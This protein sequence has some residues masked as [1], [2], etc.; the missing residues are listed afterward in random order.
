MAR[1]SFR[2]IIGI[3]LV[4]AIAV[5]AALMFAPLG[6][7]K[8]GSNPIANAATTAK[9]NALNAA[10]DAS[11]VKSAVQDALVSHSGDIAQATGLATPQVQTAIENLDIESWQAADLP[12]N[13]QPKQTIDGTYAGVDASVTTYNDPGYVTVN[14]YGQTI[15]LAVPAS[16]QQSMCLLNYA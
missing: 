2:V 1:R 16:A 9:T 10:I 14:A 15:T 7:G 11:G 6:N 8:A 12:A 13:A 4:C 3:L 5:V